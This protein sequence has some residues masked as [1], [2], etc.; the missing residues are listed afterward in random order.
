M[1]IFNVFSL[2][3]GLAL[4]MYGMDV[5]GK[6]LEKAAGSKLSAILA[7]MTSSPV[8]GFL[9]GL[10]VTSIIQSSSA[11]TVMVVGFVNSGIMSLKQAIGIIMGA[12]VGTTVTAWI[13]SLTGIQ[14]DSF[15]LQM[16][17]PSSF[18]PVL[19]FIGLLL[20][21]AAKSD[22]KKNVGIIML[23]FTVLMTGMDM[24]SSS[25]EPLSEM[26][27][28]Q[29]LFVAFSNP[30]IGVLVGAIVTAIIQSS[31]A[32]VG[33]LQALSTTGAVTFGSALPIIMGQNIGTCITAILASIGTTKNAKRTSAVHL[34]F[35]ITG[36]VVCMV[37]FY[38][39]NSI[40]QFQFVNGVVDQ[41]GIA[42]VH[43]CFNVITT[44]ILLP[45]A[46][47]LEKLAIAT[48]KDSPEKE[49]FA[50]LDT[51]LLNTP[52]VA[53]DRSKAVAGEMAQLA[54]DGFVKAT[55]TIGEFTDKMLEEIRG[56]EK[57]VDK[58]EDKLGSYLVQ[59]A[60]RDMTT[61]HSHEVSKILHV[62][63]DFERVSDYSVNIAYAAKEMVEKGI[64]FSKEAMKEI[65]L[66]KTATLELAELTNRAFCND[67]VETAQEIEPLQHVVAEMIEEIKNNHIIRLKNKECTIELGFVLSDV[68]NA[69]ERGAAHCS[70]IA[71]AVIEAVTDGYAPHASARSYRKDKTSSYRDNYSK[72]KEK[73]STLNI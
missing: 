51:L 73:Y 44:A 69:Y 65:S 57:Q 36:V 3:G 1:S 25:V 16:L 67:D 60:D 18:A 30:I 20:Y 63:N 38:S 28:F 71:I 35:N 62:I 54:L 56:M 33:I 24:M 7:T 34:Y 4:F 13:I 66:L 47:F 64:T 15:L 45:C 6:A 70:N 9:L 5:M 2:M 46:G 29:E 11:T 55:D 52:A 49:E 61:A 27:W 14:G 58:Y 21:M 68:L 12:N 10:G 43:T 41:R 17:K 8:R 37:L 22:K 19:A 50:L 59:L 31:S 42:I 32:S 39:L 23:G 53:V 40:F 48:I 26:P 72:Y